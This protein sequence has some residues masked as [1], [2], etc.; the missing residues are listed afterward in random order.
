MK[1][2]KLKLSGP[3]R[4]SF[5]KIG[6]T[7]IELLV[8]I[9][10]IAILAALLLPAL[11]RAKQKAQGVSCM[12]NL[13]QLQL[14]WMMYA[15]DN[16]DRLVPVGG[17]PDLV[18]TVN[19]TF[20]ALKPQWVFG[21]VDSTDSATNTWFLENGLLYPYVRTAKPYKCPADPNKYKGQPVIRSMSMNCWLNPISIWDPPATE[22]VYRKFSELKNPSKTFV[23]I[24]EAAYSLDDGFFVCTPDKKQWVNNPASYHG[25]G[26]GISFADGH[27]EIKVWKDGNLLNANKSA[28]LVGT[29]VNPVIPSENLVWLQE[30]STTLR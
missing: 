16:Q 28:K 5:R 18:V 22:I 19:P 7:L 13:K 21:R 17:I 27:M 15:D 2:T 12:N 23:L 26:G 25:N 4:T 14:S 8:V 1:F 9:A 3:R 29:W 30:R 11:G 24:D 20:A 6:F 10:I